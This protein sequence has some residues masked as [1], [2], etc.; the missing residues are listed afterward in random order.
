MYYDR[1]LEYLL[2]KE[3]ETRRLEASKRQAPYE[4]RKGTFDDARAWLASRV[5]WPAVDVSAKA[6]DAVGYHGGRYWRR[7]YTRALGLIFNGFENLREAIA[8][9]P[10]MA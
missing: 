8:N 7:A 6:V 10:S 9:R 1:K 2:N 3:A 4:F 5:I